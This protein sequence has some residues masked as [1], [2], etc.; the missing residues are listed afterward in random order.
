MSSV[1]VGAGAACSSSHREGCAL[2]RVALLAGGSFSFPFLSLF[3]FSSF[4]S[5]SFM[6]LPFFF[7]SLFVFPY[8][9]PFFILFFS[10]PL[11]LFVFF[12]HSFGS[13]FLIPL[14]SGEGIFIR[15]GGRDGYPTL[16]QLS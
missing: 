16:V 2:G 15:G 6:F 3:V 4:L 7:F 8:F 10:F 14:P 13:L 12:F 9:S 5:L 11:I 1:L